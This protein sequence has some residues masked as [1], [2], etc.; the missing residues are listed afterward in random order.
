M[1]SQQA[2]WDRRMPGDGQQKWEHAEVF[3]RFSGGKIVPLRFVLGSAVFTVSKVNYAWT[4]RKG[5]V[6]LHLFSV[7]DTRDT[8]RLCFDP[9]TMSWQVS[10]LQ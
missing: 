1:F 4:E 5:K 6:L 9:E 8:Y 7:S 2:R 10:P 3:C